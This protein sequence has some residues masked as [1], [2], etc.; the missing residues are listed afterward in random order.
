MTNSHR[1]TIEDSYNARVFRALPRPAL[2]AISLWLCAAYA[3][4]NN[5][6]KVLH[7]ALTTLKDLGVTIRV[8]QDKAKIIRS[9][10]RLD[11][12]AVQAA[13]YAAAA[14]RQLGSG[15]VGDQMEDYARE[16]YVVLRG[17][18]HGFEKDFL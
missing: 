8:Q 10:C 17:S 12:A 11:M 5:V 14:Y 4:R 1:S 18:M 6:T 9:N 3:L 2:H 15:V 13:T 16:L 7:W